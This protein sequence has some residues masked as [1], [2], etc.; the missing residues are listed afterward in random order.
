MVSTTYHFFQNTNK[1]T[2]STSLLWKFT[3]DWLRFSLFGEPTL[4]LKK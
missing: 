3:F 1:K 4:R 2:T